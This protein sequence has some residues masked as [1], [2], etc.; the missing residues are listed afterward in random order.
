[1]AK[2]ASLGQ[3]LILSAESG[4][5]MKPPELQRLREY[6]ENR[7]YS[8]KVVVYLRPWKSW[9]ESHFQQGVKIG[10]DRV[11]EL[12]PRSFFKLLVYRDR[13]Q[14]LEAV[15]GTD[16]VDAHN[17][18]PKIFPNGCIVQDFC[19]GLGINLDPVQIRLTNESLSLSAIK[20]L[21]TYRKL[22]PGFGRGKW[23]VLSNNLLAYIALVQLPGA[24]V[25]FH[26]S[27]VEP[28]LKELTLQRPWLEQ[29][30][31]CRFDADIYKRLQ[32]K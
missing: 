26:S 5:Y 16:Q 13:L 18:H 2:A 9:L 22:G 21:Y 8:V 28:L 17:Y 32:R 27:L 30:L 3:T 24:P 11:I 14:I 1:M 31:G 4:W 6:M 10:N 25:R 12:P 19:Q 7:G 23:A 29:R 20:L 15:F